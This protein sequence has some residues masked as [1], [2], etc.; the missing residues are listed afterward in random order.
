MIL[1]PVCTFD[2]TLWSQGSTDSKLEVP[3]TRPLRDT[4]FT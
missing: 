1:G 2:D 4:V 3:D